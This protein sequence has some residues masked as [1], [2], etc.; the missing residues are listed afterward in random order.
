[1]LQLQ[2]FP[3]IIFAA[4]SLIAAYVF[5]VIPLYFIFQKAGEKGYKA[6]IPFYNFYIYMKIC[7]K[8]Y[9]FWITLSLALSAV[10]LQI[11]SFVFYGGNTINI[12]YLI[13]SLIAIP[14]CVISILTSV[15]MSKAFGHGGGFALG[16]IFFSL[17][18]EYI[19]AF[20]SSEYYGN[21]SYQK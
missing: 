1:M 2:L 19:L 21:P 10:V 16:L 7:W 9:M 15:K 14:G 18:F 6:I 8:P 3:I 13:S 20:G 12:F 17:I 4:I 5:S 11:L